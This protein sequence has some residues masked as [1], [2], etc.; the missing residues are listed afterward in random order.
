MRVAICV[1]VYIVNFG[2]PLFSV[3]GTDQIV[4]SQLKKNK[5]SLKLASQETEKRLE[6]DH[7]VPV[8]HLH[9]SSAAS[10]F[11]PVPSLKSAQISHNI[12]C[13]SDLI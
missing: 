3:L 7:L 12:A 2:T 10:P 8:E 1:A 13:C 4:A 6:D 9:N 11:L 5:L